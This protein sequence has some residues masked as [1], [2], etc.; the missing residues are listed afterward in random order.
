MG[1]HEWLLQ[2]GQK[3]EVTDELK[4]WL[5]VYRNESKRL[6]MNIATA[7]IS[8]VQLLTEQLPQQERLEFLQAQLLELNRCSQLLINA[9]SLLMELNGSTATLLTQPQ[10][11]SLKSTDS[12]PK[13]LT[14]PTN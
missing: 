13:T 4:Q 8:L 14:P 11:D 12:N 2:R 10:T 9:A 5:E 6:L 3:Y 1:I 7:S